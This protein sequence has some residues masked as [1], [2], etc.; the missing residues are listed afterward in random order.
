MQHNQNL[1]HRCTTQY[2]LDGCMDSCSL[3]LLILDGA[4]R[5]MLLA[6]MLYPP[7]KP[8]SLVG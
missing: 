5:Q 4:A 2:F 1:S 6:S 7:D 3:R 8:F